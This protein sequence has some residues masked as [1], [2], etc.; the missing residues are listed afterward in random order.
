MMEKLIYS[1]IDY[2]TF[3][4]RIQSIKGEAFVHQQSQGGI[5]DS[6]FMEEFKQSTDMEM[7]RMDSITA[8]L[9][10][11]GKKKKSFSFVIEDN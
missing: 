8:K 11:N 3:E 2:D 1:S 4:E 7:E 5:T 9:S 6:D 10:G